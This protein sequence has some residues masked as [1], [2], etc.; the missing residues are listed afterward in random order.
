MNSLTAEAIGQHLLTEGLTVEVYSCVASTNGLVKER[1]ENGADE[2][3]VVIADSQSAGRGRLG[4][5]FCSPAGTG[6]YMSILIRPQ[7]AV[8]RAMSV[9]TLAA[10]A[11]CRA[12]EQLS[13]RKATI[14]WVNDV[15]CDGKKVCGIL[16]EAAVSPEGLSYAVLGIGIN[17]S[18]PIDGYPAEI[19]DRAASVYGQQKG[20]RAV[21]AAAVIDA[22]FEEYTHLEQSGYVKEYIGRS[23]LVNTAIVVHT[24][25]GEKAATALGV[26]EQCRLLVRYEDGREETLSSGDVSI[27]LA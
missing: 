3:L 5:S 17:V 11:V 24:P 27:R 8:E 25:A 7:M 1:A 20:D 12:I 15:Y 10:V 19:A 22:F 4:R 16:T 21:F 6:L 14:K 18:D 26:D 23:C 2:G 13:D 9:T